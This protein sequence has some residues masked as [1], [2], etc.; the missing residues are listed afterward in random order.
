MCGSCTCISVRGV[1]VEKAGW[2]GGVGGWFL[3][4]WAPQDISDVQDNHG[5]G[6]DDDND[7]DNG[8]DDDGSDDDDDDDSDDRR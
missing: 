3:G 5:S 2:G 8:D 7:D 1:L 6:D 4:V